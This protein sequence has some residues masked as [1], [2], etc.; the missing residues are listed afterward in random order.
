MRYAILVGLLLG[1]LG[2]S[3][4]YGQFAYV[5]FDEE[6]WKLD[7]ESGSPTR[8][9]ATGPRVAALAFDA[10][11]TLYGVD[12]VENHL[13]LLN[14]ETGAASVVGDLGDWSFDVRNPGDPDLAFDAVGRLWLEARYTSDVLPFGASGFF[15][16]DRTTGQATH[17]SDG[18]YVWAGL[19]RSGN[20]LVV[21]RGDN[22]LSVLDENGAIV[23]VVGGPSLPEGATFS[24]L[25]VDP[26]G[27]IWTVWYEVACLLGIGI[28]CDT[29]FSLAEI[30][31]Q[32]GKL[33]ATR[34][35]GLIGEF[36][37]GP[38]LRGFAVGPR[39]TEDR[40]PCLPSKTPAATLLLPYFEVDVEEPNG[41]DTLVSV[42]NVADT[43]ALVHAVLWTNWGLP[44]LSF[45]FFVPADGIRSLRIRDLIAGRLPVTSPP[46]RP[47]E[48]AASCLEPLALPVFDPDAL[49]ATLTGQPDPSDGLCHSSAVESGRLVTGFLTFDVVR[50]CSGAAL[51]TPLDDGYFEDGGGGLATND[52]VLW[53]DF[54]LVDPTNDYAEGERL[55]AVSADASR[56]GGPVVCITAP[57]PQRTATTFYDRPEGNRAPLAR[58]YRARYLS[59]GGFLGTTDLVIWQEG[60]SG[61]NG[62]DSSPG[63]DASIFQLYE[64]FHDE[65]GQPVASNHFFGREHTLRLRI[66]DERAPVASG[67]GSVDLHGQWSGGFGVPD[68]EDTQIWAMPLLSAEGRFSVGIEA[69]AIEDFCP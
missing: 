14:V 27:R 6:L 33:V 44:A 34:P 57:C 29:D 2:S 21:I 41:R 1:L 31:P 69:V 55:V 19:T 52:N 59:G 7:L 51:T 26:S 25:D 35:T 10:A 60:R 24:G 12:L 39:Q 61:P 37:F 20:D 53:G 36:N 22:Q 28:P 42:G 38:Y 47:P 49:L 65:T 30:A 23:S 18:D 13:L 43:A 63:T 11:G 58:T 68:V 5:I 62:C 15:S 3:A 48:V 64:D 16:I 32:T 8:V 9:G 46:D 45:D 50:D 54:Y 4:L 40:E 56:F 17:V 67:F 66:G